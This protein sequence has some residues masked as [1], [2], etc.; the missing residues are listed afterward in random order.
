M[1]VPQV[2]VQE[3]SRRTRKGAKMQEQGLRSL[4]VYAVSRMAML[5]VWAAQWYEKHA[6]ATLVP[7]VQAWVM[8]HVSCAVVRDT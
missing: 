2:W 8:L 1:D 7:K 6:R 4:L 5:W 3:W